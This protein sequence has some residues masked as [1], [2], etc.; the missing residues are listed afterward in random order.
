MALKYSSTLF[1]WGAEEG[2]EGEGKKVS[3][4]IFVWLEI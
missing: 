4:T 2:K 3:I 1:G